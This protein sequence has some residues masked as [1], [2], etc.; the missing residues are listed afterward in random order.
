VKLV[1]FID[2][3][4]MPQLDAF[5]TQNAIALLRQHFDYEHWYDIGKLALKEV[6]NTQTLACMNPSAGSFQVNNRFQRHFWTV[7]IPFPDTESLSLIYSTFL[8][9]HLKRFKPTLAEPGQLIVRSALALH[10]TVITS[11]RKTAINFHYEFN[12]RHLSN[13]FQ[14]L[15]LSDPAKFSEPD[16]LVKLWIHES[17]RTYGDRLVSYEHLNKY[18]AAMFEMVKK[19]FT[20]FQLNKFFAPKDPENLLFCNFT[21]GYNGERLYDIMPNH[22]MQDIIEEGLREYNDN[23][24]VMNL[25]LFEDAMKHVCRISRIIMPSSGHALLV[26]VG[27]SGKQSLSKLTSFMMF[28]TPFMITIS[29][30]YGMADLKTDLQALYNKTGIKDEAILF[31]FTEGQISNERFLVYLND[32]LSSGEIAELYATEDKDVIINAVR[33]KVK[34]EGKPDTKDNCWNYFIGKVK[35]NLHMSLCFSPVGE[36]L[37]RRARQ[38]P[39]LVNC[40]VIDW[41]FPW[42]KN[43]LYD[44][45][46]KFLAHLDMDS[47]DIRKGV[48]S[49]MPNS[50]EVVN[51]LS[52][53]LY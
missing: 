4:N 52:T 23:N 46:E 37:R 6:I 8:M 25:V 24:A 48:V 53:R 47:D 29:S 36:S 51:R 40:T 49:F 38:F 28:M 41:F 3:L 16:K 21:A 33:S 20:K 7:S 14:G 32:L 1:Y 18:I 35:Q 2:D 5:D 34:A 26:G 13:I 10:Q 27:G 39:A 9:G 17:E 31:L 44:V 15:L 45:A 12:L 11:F 22:K 50:F 43:A 30:S 42:P 19:S